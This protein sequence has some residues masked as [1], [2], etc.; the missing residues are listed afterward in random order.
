MIVCCLSGV[1][2]DNTRNDSRSR[3]SKVRHDRQTETQTNNGRTHYHAVHA[4]F[5]GDKIIKQP[6]KNTL[7]HSEVGNAA[8][9]AEGLRLR[10]SLGQV[11]RPVSTCYDGAVPLPRPLCTAG[12]T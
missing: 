11:G 2:K 3:L 4:T 1:I 10:T 6:T 5:A 9:A 12:E 8:A 7:V